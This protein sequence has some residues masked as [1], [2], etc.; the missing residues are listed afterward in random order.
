MLVHLSLFHSPSLNQLISQRERGMLRNW[1][2]ATGT[3][4]TDGDVACV[5]LSVYVQRGVWQESN[6][7]GF[8]SSPMKAKSKACQISHSS[9]GMHTSTHKTTRVLISQLHLVSPFSKVSLLFHFCRPLTPPS[10]FYLL[11][12]L[13]LLAPSIFFVLFLPMAFPASDKCP[14]ERKRESKMEKKKR[15]ESRGRAWCSL[16]LCF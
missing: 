1:K 12:P 15:R 6:G 5:E 10:L 4:Q 14:E 3:S 7:R 13:Q 11:S 16:L 9:S 8:I 2:G